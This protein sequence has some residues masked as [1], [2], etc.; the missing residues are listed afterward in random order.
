MLPRFVPNT[1]CACTPASPLAS[2][3]S[4]PPPPPPPPQLQL[5]RRQKRILQ[6]QYHHLR[7][8]SSMPI[9]VKPP[10]LFS[11]LIPFVTLVNEFEDMPPAYVP[12][13][14]LVFLLRFQFCLFETFSFLLQC[15]LYPFFFATDEIKCE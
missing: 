7:L 9:S 1:G 5:S 10:P 15:Q 3:L 11:K 12:M 14:R 2:R 6:L 8:I 4:P 13:A